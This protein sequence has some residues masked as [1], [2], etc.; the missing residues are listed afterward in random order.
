MLHNHYKLSHFQ[1]P[2][3]SLR[4]AVSQFY[5]EVN[6]LGVVTLGLLLSWV[7]ASHVCFLRFMQHHV[8]YDEQKSCY[9]PTV[10]RPNIL[11][12]LIDAITTGMVSASSLSKTL[13]MH[14]NSNIFVVNKLLPVEICRAPK[15]Y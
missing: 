3:A 10:N 6:S 7:Q 14:R 4:H 2:I 9:S 15:R 1:V 8:I 11:Q 13:Q 12:P 5:Q